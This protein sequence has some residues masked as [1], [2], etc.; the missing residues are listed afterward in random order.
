MI[1][2]LSMRPLQKSVYKSIMERNAELMEALARANQRDAAGNLKPT[3][4]KAVHNMLM[5]L[6]K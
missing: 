1:V 5:Q 2:P 6:R 4:I 3:K